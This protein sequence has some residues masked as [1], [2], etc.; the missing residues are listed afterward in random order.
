MES[1]VRGQ[2]RRQTGSNRA[3]GPEKTAAWHSKSKYDACCAPRAVQE[4]MREAGFGHAI[5]RRPKAA[6]EGREAFEKA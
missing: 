3:C 2:A 4:I 5:P 1:K 6:P